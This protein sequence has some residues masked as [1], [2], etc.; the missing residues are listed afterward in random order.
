M[1]S[2]FGF[3]DFG[4]RLMCAVLGGKIPFSFAYLY[5]IS[6]V[7]YGIGTNV[8]LHGRNLAT[9][10]TFAIGEVK[11]NVDSINFLLSW[12]LY[13]AGAMFA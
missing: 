5:S 12:S 11:S 10:Y 6:T 2:A 8:A 1:L 3:A 9:M 13:V 7:V 4:G